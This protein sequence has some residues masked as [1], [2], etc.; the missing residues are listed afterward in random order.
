MG[1]LVL[2]SRRLKL[3][4]ARIG[5]AKEC[6][7]DRTPG[8]AGTDEVLRPEL[9]VDDIAVRA[10][11]DTAHVVGARRRTAAAQQVVVELE[12]ADRVLHARKRELQPLQMHHDSV[13]GV[14]PMRVRL[15]VEVKV[16]DHLRGDPSRAELRAGELRPV[17]H[18]HGGAG[19]HEARS[20]GR[21]GRPAADDD[22]VDRFHRSA[23]R[24]IHRDRVDVSTGP[25]Y[26]VVVGR[27]AHYLEELDGV[28]KECG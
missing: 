13:E 2:V 6:A 10:G 14:E 17:E 9:A 7:I 3:A 25:R 15:D 24:G 16:G 27:R 21:A 22:D 23:A 12:T 28:R 4:G 20:A 11:L 18:Q 19:P 8:A 1:E 26:V 5:L